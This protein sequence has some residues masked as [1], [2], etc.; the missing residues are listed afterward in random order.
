MIPF[1]APTEDIL[2]SLEHV[3]RASQ[4][5]DWD[6]ETTREVLEHFSSLAEDVIAPLNVLGDQQG[7]RFENGTVRLPDGFA[8]AYSQLIEGGWQ[9]LG[10]PEEFGG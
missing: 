4:L 2:F 1:K 10:A 9:G 3:A 5:G 7:A 8:D 6:L